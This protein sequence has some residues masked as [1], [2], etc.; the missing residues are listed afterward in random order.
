MTA[1]L[2]L[3][4]VVLL[5]ALLPAIFLA[6][7]IAQFADYHNLA[8]QRPI[9]GIAHFWNIVSNLPFLVVGLMGL[10]QLSVRREDA[11]EAWA[12]VFGGAALVAFGSSWYHADPNDV[13]LIWDRL[14]IG[15]AFMGFLVALLIEHLDEMHGRFARLQ[16]LP[17]TLLSVVAIWWWKATGDLSLWVWVQVAPMLAVVLVLALLPGRYSHR[18]YLAYALACYAAAKLFELGDSQ[19]MQWSGGIVSGHVLKHLAAAAGVWCFYV[20]LRQRSA[21]GGKT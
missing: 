16:L 3:L 21:L 20:M 9:L 15:V 10:R 14:P 6:G 2:Q 17:L 19:V 13:T 1:R 12:M 4:V 18:R 11:A 5:A 8:D 7:P